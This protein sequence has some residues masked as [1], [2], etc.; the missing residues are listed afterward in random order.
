MLT[1]RP[2]NTNASIVRDLAA[3]CAEHCPKA[4]ICIISNPFNSTVPIFAEVFKQKGVY[5]EKRSAWVSPPQ[6]H[7]AILMGVIGSSA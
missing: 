5:D 1:I 6:S 2:Q 4:M 7:Q 3:A